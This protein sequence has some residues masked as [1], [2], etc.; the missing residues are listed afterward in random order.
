MERTLQPTDNTARGWGGL[1]ARVAALLVA[2][3]LP[4]AA[5]AYD[6]TVRFDGA[7][8]LKVGMRFDTVN[9][10]LGDHL[11][12]PARVGRGTVCFQLAPSE[13]PGVLLMFVDDVLKRVDVV[14][15]GVL[16]DRGIG[17]GD[18]QELVLRG[19][20]EAVRRA[21]HAH[22]EREQYLTVKAGEGQYAIR[23]ET[24]QGRI[25]AFYAGEWRTVQ[26]TDACSSGR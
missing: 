3:C 22:D 8:P 7:G 19:Y 4:L 18:A 21:P 2:L 15:P 17:V 23:F 16:S 25:T 14:E 9:K 6:W 11:E 20:G 1:C 26:N 13:Q 10:V 5:R 24:S 12:R